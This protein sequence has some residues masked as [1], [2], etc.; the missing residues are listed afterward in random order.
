MLFIIIHQTY[1]L[2]FKELIH[3]FQAAQK[4]VYVGVALIGLVGVTIDMVF[5][6]IERRM[7]HWVGR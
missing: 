2:W 7:L 6:I 4:S 5:L 1:E 3:E